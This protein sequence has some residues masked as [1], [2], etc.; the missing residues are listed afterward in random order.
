MRS[1]R[2]HPARRFAVFCFGAALAGAAVL[3][4]WLSPPL[5]LL[6]SWLIAITGVAF[7][8]YGYDKLTAVRGWMRVPESILLG[9]SFAGGTLGA[10]AGMNL[11]R[12]KTVKRSF[13]L[14]F[15]LLLA[16]QIALVAGYYFHPEITRKFG[17]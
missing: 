9:L 10:Y 11:F 14:K 6:Q 7:F 4:L 15:W 13:R 1:A 17:A 3:Y 8:G 12:H 2:V 5:D 16:L